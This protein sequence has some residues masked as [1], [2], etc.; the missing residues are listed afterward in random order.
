[1]QKCLIATS[2]I[3]FQFFPWFFYLIKR[4]FI[5]IFSL[6][7]N[8]SIFSWFFYKLGDFE[9]S[10]LFDFFFKLFYKLESFSKSY[11]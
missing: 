4:F 1:M 2:F 3:E 10:N 5:N 9:L 11:K 7:I 8:F 6:S